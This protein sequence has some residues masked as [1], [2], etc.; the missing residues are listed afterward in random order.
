MAPYD[1]ASDIYQALGGG[2][3]SPAPRFALSELWESFD[4]W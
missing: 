3:C 4:E 2:E 1:V